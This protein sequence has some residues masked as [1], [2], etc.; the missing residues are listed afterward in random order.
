MPSSDLENLTSIASL[1]QT[2]F[3][4]LS[5]FFVG[6]QIREQNR[7]TRAA[8]TQT[9]LALA[10][11]FLLQLSQD[12]NLAKLWMD[13]AI[14]YQKLDKVEQF[15]YLQLLFW[16]MNLH[17]N[18]FYQHQ[19]G[20]IDQQIYAGWQIEL[21]NFIRDKH[22]KEFWDKDMKSLFRTEFGQLVETLIQLG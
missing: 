4:I 22:I 6:Y 1:I 3:V 16:W 19:N 2:F 21:R 20:L 9:V 14:H 17:E 10:S 8:N 7:L 15:R 12:Q 13:G 11:P 18:I 5:V